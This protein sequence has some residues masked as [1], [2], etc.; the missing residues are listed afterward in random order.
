MNAILNWIHVLCGI[1]VMPENHNVIECILTGKKIRKKPRQSWY[2]YSR[3]QDNHFTSS[4]YHVS[5]KCDQI[6]GIGLCVIKN[7]K[8]SRVSHIVNHRIIQNMGSACSSVR[9]IWG[10]FHSLCSLTELPSQNAAL[11]Y[12]L[13][14]VK[15][16][17]TILVS[18]RVRS[19][20]GKIHT[21]S[22]NH[23]W[24]LIIL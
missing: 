22:M 18:C 12:S 6:L 9:F 24:K 20:Y 16:S 2:L 11:V 10:N 3:V 7:N 5:L 19:I 21:I 8:N 23:S 1:N 15:I 17:R 13:I 14:S 4:N